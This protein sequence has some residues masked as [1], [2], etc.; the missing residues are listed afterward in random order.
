LGIK[1]SGGSCHQSR[2]DL[3]RV[4]HKELAEAVPLSPALERLYTVLGADRL[5]VVPLE[6]VAQRE[7]VLHAVRRHGELIDHLRLDPLLLVR[8]EE[9][10]IY[11]V[12]VVT[13]DVAGRPDGIQDLQVGLS[14]EPERPAALLGVDRRRPQRQGAS[15]RG[16]ASEQ[17]PAS[18]TA[19]P[20]L[21]NT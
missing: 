6:S 10:V 8:P 19:H 2:R 1:S 4:C 5:P 15:R 18:E 20:Q 14:H 9:G 13:R 3:P 17:L 7:G 12:A 11:E 21:P 16:R